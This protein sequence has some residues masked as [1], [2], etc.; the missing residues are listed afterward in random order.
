M[1]SLRGD[2]L[3]VL[4]QH[5]LHTSSPTYRS[6]YINRAYL[7][8]ISFLLNSLLKTPIYSGYWGVLTSFEY[9][10]QEANTKYMEALNALR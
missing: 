6:V 2:A 5:R 10:V 8:Y 4:P 9:L 1:P 7:R 3:R